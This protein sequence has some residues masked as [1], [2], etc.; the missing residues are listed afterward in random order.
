VTSPEDPKTLDADHGS[1]DLIA[2]RTW[3]RKVALITALG[4]SCAAL[5]I[6]FLGLSQFDLPIVR[7]VR[8]VTIHR[9][10]NQLTIPWMAFTSDA[11]NWIGEGTHLVAVS[12]VLLAVGW[13]FSKA[14]IK[15]AGIQTLLAHGLAALVVN[16]LKHLIGRPRPKFAHSGEWQ[17]APSWASGLDSFPSGHS[18]VSFAVATV[19]AKRFPAF[20]PLCIGVAA[21]VALSRI[22]RGS[23]FPTDVLGGAIAGAISGAIAAA[24][25]KEWRRS[26]QDGIRQAAMGASMALALLWALSRPV[27]E[28]IVAALFIGLG[29]VVTASGLWLRRMEWIGNDSSGVSR[30]TTLSL[31]LIAYGL[32]SLTASPYV[33]AAVGFACVAVW[34]NAALATEE[35]KHHAR[36]WLVMRES[37]LLCV[38]LVV[39]LI[40]YNGRGVLPF[41]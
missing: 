15:A 11:G 31:I 18:A 10:W 36:P 5:G 34:L 4:C 19:L 7:Y 3:L 22:L 8:S 37:A 28:G 38:V 16:G 14:T 13:V 32:A 23:H 21:F 9:P 35:E 20:G 6:A 40:L 2:G 33:A 27:E 1:S 24:P 12:L 41:R 30:Q 17:L 39:L 26:L 29:L 25:L